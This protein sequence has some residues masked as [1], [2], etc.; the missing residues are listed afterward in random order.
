MKP[1]KGD[2]DNRTCRRCDHKVDQ[3]GQT[4]HQ[5]QIEL[6]K[7]QRRDAADDDREGQSIHHACHQF[8]SDNPRHVVR[9]PSRVEMARTVTVML[10]IPALPP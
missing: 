7:P 6:L 8:T 10:W 5:P 3:H 1:V 9:T 4:A 2:R